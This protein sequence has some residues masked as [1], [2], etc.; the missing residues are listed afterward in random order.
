MICVR[1]AAVYKFSDTGRGGREG[2]SIGQKEMS[3]P[4]WWDDGTRTN[5]SSFKVGRTR[6]CERILSSASSSTGYSGP[7]TVHERSHRSR[8]HLSSIVR[9]ILSSLVLVINSNFIEFYYR[10]RFYWKIHDL[11]NE[12][13]KGS[14]PSW[15][16]ITGQL[17]WR[18]YF[19]TM[20]CNNPKYDVMVGN[21]ICLQIPWKEDNTQFEKWKNG[22]TGYPFI[23]A[24]MRQ[25][26]QEGWT[27]HTVRNVT[28]VFLT[29]GDLWLNWERVVNIFT[30]I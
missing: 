4:R 3:T 13:N 19:Y 18:E 26:L 14:P 17:I 27:H 12:V 5:G 20:C 25:L 15:I 11:F 2:N 23:D 30:I 16:H 24:G 22:Q 1:Y 8:R 10:H 7:S 6:V 28:A 21:P 9:R 29:R